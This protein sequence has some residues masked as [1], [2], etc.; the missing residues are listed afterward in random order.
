VVLKLQQSN[1]SSYQG[2]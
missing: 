2:K 1:Q